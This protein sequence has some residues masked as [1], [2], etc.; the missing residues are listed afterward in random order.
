MGFEVFEVIVLVVLVLTLTYKVGKR[1]CRREGW[2]AKRKEA[3]L[4]YEAGKLE[5]LKQKLEKGSETEP[6]Q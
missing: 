5:K 4:K 6:K 2:I 3:K 1:I